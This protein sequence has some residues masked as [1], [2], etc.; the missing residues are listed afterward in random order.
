MNKNNKIRISIIVACFNDGH[1]IREALS[2]A[3]T[4]LDDIYEVII[5]NDGS[6]DPLTCQVL[7]ELSNT[8][9]KVIHQS[10][11][12]VAAARN[13]GIR[14]AQGE[15]ILPLD[16]D[17]HIHPAYIY[18]GIEILDKFSNVAVV[19]CDVERFGEGISKLE[20]IP[21]Y[22]LDYENV[23]FSNGFKAI[24]KVPEF[25]LSLLVN[26]NYIDACAVFRKSIGIECG[27]YDTNTPFGC[28]SDWDLWLSIAKKGY[29]FYH[30]PE[31]LLNYRIRSDSLST[32]ARS[33]EKAKLVYRYFA[34][35]HFAFFPKEYRYF[36]KPYRRWLKIQEIMR[37]QFNLLFS[38]TSLV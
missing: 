11:Q 2:S 17:N 13:A 4:G 14:L 10:N 33:A 20:E 24:Q 12:G 25:N 21:S 7:D 22:N 32:S 28:Y 37:S 19:Y 27:L 6:T 38:S 15:Y 3:E 26:H 1:F 34:S 8:G 31:V 9:Y 23:S 29:G 18:K 16:P 5:V 36:F 30:I 35:K